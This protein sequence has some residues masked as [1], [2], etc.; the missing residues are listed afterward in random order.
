MTPPRLHQIN[1]VCRDVEASV[2]FYRKL[3]LDL[4]EGRIWGTATGPHHVGAAAPDGAGGLAL[5]LDSVRFAQAWN[6]GWQGR[7]DVAGRI[8]LGFEVATR[9]AVDALFDEMTGAG[10]RGLQAPYDAIWG[11]RY[12]ILEDPDGTAV[13]LMSPPSP[14]MRSPPPKV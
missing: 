5:E 6:A 13:G 3:G 2:A 8:V 4:P 14:E 1:L 12:A 10:Y 9:A 11:A 7:P